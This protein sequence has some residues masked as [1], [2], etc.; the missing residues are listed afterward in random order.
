MT[1]NDAIILGKGLDIPTVDDVIN[2]VHQH[3]SQIFYQTD[4]CDE[5]KELHSTYERS[6]L[7]NTTLIKD[8]DTY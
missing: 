7:S 6:G 4:I 5:L 8:V 3:A 1:I 2:Y